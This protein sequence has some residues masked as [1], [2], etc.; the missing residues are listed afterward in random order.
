M[1]DDRKI[2]VVSLGCAKNL[3]DTEHMMGVLAKEGYSVVMRP[4]EAQIALV[5]TCGFL[6]EAVE[7][8]I[9]VILDIARHKEKGSLKRLVVAGCMVQRY[10]YKLK[11]ELPEVDAWLGSAQIPRLL[12]AIAQPGT[13]YIERPLYLPDHQVPRIRATPPYLAYLRISD[14][15][16]NRCTFCMIPKLRGPHR[17]RTLD[18]LIQEAAWMATEGVKEL[19]LVGQ[20]ITAYGRDLGRGYGLVQLVQELEKIE[21]I[22]WIRLL[23]A[24]PEGIT[25]KILDHLE[26]SKKLCPYL[27]IPFQHVSPAILSRMGRGEGYGGP[28]SLVEKI[29]N[30]KREISIRSTFMVGFPGETEA[31]FEELVEF[32]KWAR[33]EHV[34]VFVY[35]KESG[36]KAAR[37]GG[38]VPF[39]EA[40]G[41]KESLLAIQAEISEELNR[42]RVG[43][44]HDVLIEGPHEET[45]LLLKGRT[46]WMAPDVD[47]RVL[48][49]KGDG[50]V[51][52]ITKVLIT[53]AHPYDLVGGITG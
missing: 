49:N 51:G 42:A 15:C 16:S 45:D 43:Q 31:M 53:E 4:E 44:V 7:E 50:V 41:R 5:N 37:M 1:G 22:E 39:E 21:G 52:Q 46:A 38:E 27:D 18:S 36:T 32:V 8:A 26:G 9:E 12:K 28:R 10:G 6:E 47:G 2:Y 11:K 24:N 20:D 40:L 29:R 25:E 35:S 13:F 17:S 3:V 33:L 14:G 30:L 34:G 19:N 23:Y 48:I